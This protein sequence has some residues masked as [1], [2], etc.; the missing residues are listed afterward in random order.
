MNKKNKNK[1]I[2]G[3][4]F[5]VILA[6]VLWVRSYFSSKERISNQDIKT[7]T[8]TVPSN[9]SS[10][11]G[12]SNVVQ[13]QINQENKNVGDVKTEIIGRD[14]IEKQ[15]NNYYQPPS[16][17][18]KQPIGRHINDEDM[19]R[20]NTVPANSMVSVSYSMHDRESYDYATEIVNHLQSKGHL[21]ETSIST[22]TVTPNP[23]PRFSLRIQEQKASITI[24]P[25]P[26]E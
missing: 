25:L 10:D 8:Q 4:I 15:E 22:I 2:G 9:R 17:K 19:G 11:S 13:Q 7:N 26:K 20:L 24:L 5:I 14:K 3:I 16:S 12:T 1:L 6:G 23:N 18:A 21:V